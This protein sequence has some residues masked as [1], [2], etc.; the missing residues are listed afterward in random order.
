MLTVATL[1]AYLK[2]CCMKNNSLYI[3]LIAFTAAI[4]GF[5]L[6]FDG[7]VIS[8]AAP[9]YKAVFGL[10]DGSVL[11][12]FS[13]SCIIWGSIFGNLFAGPLSDRIGRK[14]ALLIAAILFIA[15][16]L[17]T[18]LANGITVFIIGRIVAGVAVGVAIIVAPVYIAEVAPAKKRGWLVSFNQLLIVIGLSAAYFSNYFILKAINDPLTNWRWMLGIE[19]VPSVLYF[20]FL[21]FIPESPRWLIMHGKDNKAMDILTKV[22]GSDHAQS[23]FENIK[24]TLLYKTGAGMAAQAKELFT[25]KMKLILVIGFGLAIFQQLSGIN[26][27]LYYAPMIFETAGG[28]RDTAFMQAVVLGLVFMVLTIASM[29]F[30]DRLGRKPLLYAGVAMM[31]LSLLITGIVFKNARYIVEQNSIINAANEIVKEDVWVQ[32]KKQFPALVTYSNVNLKDRY[33]E[34]FDKEKMISRIELSS[35]EMKTAI[36]N[37]NLFIEKVTPLAGKI[38][39]NELD[40][41]GAVRNSLQNTAVPAGPYLPLLLKSAIHINPM[42][43]L[44]SIL[45]FI[46]GFSISLGPVMW[47]MFSEIFPNRLRGLA[48][49][50]VG[51][52]NAVTSF[53][54]AT[55]FPMQLNKFGSS[56]TYFIYAGFMFLCLW[57]VWKYVVETKGKSLEEIEHQL[58]K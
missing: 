30:I 37:K 22:G 21:L 13:V 26:A 52:V 6:G 3:I 54:V 43:V 32:T 29:F 20:L 48:I 34:V 19:A 49:S 23:E 9:F 16:S 45:G 10:Q 15:S 8:G 53:L 46:A 14:P 56:A 33:A 42:I 4:G 51:A 11:F 39:E 5:L 50:V 17:L 7:S 40:F 58:V 38:F 41:Y 28:G 25:K 44:I 1:S 12:G 36:E 27:I 31:A 57:F 55:L 18:A 35:P 47:A 24:K 2:F